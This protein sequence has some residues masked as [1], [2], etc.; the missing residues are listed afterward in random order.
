MCVNQYQK[1]VEHIISLLT[2]AASHFAYRLLLKTDRVPEA[3]L[4]A[5]TYLPSRISRAVELW[6]K[7]LGKISDRAAAALAD[8]AEYPNLFP[9]LDW[10]HKVEAVFH[11]KRGIAIPASNYS[12]V[13]T[14]LSIWEL[15]VFVVR[16]TVYCVN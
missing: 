2:C 1:E 13:L 6:R 5:R 4:F 12:L 14:A 15:L 11:D 16:I 10:A 9:D 3:A 7:D 8:P